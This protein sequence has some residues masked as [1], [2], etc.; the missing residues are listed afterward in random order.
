MSDFMRLMN[1]L[2]AFSVDL[3]KM[4]NDLM[5]MS[6]GPRTGLSEILLPP[7]EP[8]SSIMP[9]KV[10]PSIMEAVNMVCF[11]VQGNRLAVEN[12]AGSGLFD[13]N[14]Y[15]PVMA[16]N[17]FN[18]LELL[19]NAVSALDTRCVQGIEANREVLEGYY[20]GS[21]A[22][23]TILSPLIGYEKAAELARASPETGIN[24]GELAVIRGYITQGDLDA[25]LSTPTGPNLHIIKMIKE[26][27]K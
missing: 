10:N 19:T 20:T 8:G 11:Q 27:E 21:N 6:S 7:V 3:V 18:S 25:I 16:F 9:G 1:A 22:M 14:V 2:S 12:A 4:N 17:I 13:L 15:T 23:V 5:L 24:A 26:K